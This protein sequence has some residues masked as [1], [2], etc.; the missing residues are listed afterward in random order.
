MARIVLVIALLVGM[1]AAA[2]FAVGG[3]KGV[4]KEIFAQAMPVTY[5]EP[6]ADRPAEFKQI[7]GNVYAFTYGFS[8]SLVLDTSEGLAV[9]DTFHA[10]FAQT[11][12]AALEEEFPGKPIKW[13]IYSHNHLDHIRGSVVLEAEEVIGHRLVNYFASDWAHATDIAPVTRPV[14]GDTVMTLGGID[15]EFLYM[16]HSHSETIYGFHIPSESAVFAADMMFVRAVPPFDFPDFYYPGYV[17]ALD[18][19]I[20][21]DA[22][23]YVPSHLD[24]GSRQDLIDFRNMT[25]AFHEAIQAELAKNNYNASQGDKMRAGL[26]AAYD[27]LEPEYGDW[28]GFNE[29]FVPKF[30]RHWGGLYL[31]Y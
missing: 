3:E 14:D 29:M 21:L 13:V 6:Y 19:L 27:K 4:R 17:R 24:E 12:K 9:F 31:G 7:S 15:V 20:A 1:G 5:F 26:K 30:G 11:L 8:R 25:V 22:D 10:K 2:F 23:H 16:P 18:R 28:H